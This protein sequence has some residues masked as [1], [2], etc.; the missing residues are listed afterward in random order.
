MGIF[1]WFPR[2]FI[3]L[4]LFAEGGDGSGTGDAGADAAGQQA[5]SEPEAPL[6]NPKG[7]RRNP[8]ADVRYGRQ[9]E[10]E[11]PAAQEET[12]EQDD[13]APG[14]DERAE[15]EALK[16]GKFAKFY[17]EDVSTTVR[18]RLKNSKQSDETLAKLQ[19]IL[20]E[21]SRKS[22]VDVGDVDGLVSHFLD[23]DSLYEE[24]AMQLNMPVKTLK[25]MK[26][27][28][29]SNAAYKAQQEAEE[30]ER[31]FSEHMARLSQQGEQ[32]KALYPG[33][34][35]QQELQDPRF[36]RLTSPE[37][38]MDV[39]TAYFALHHRELQ[40]ATVQGTVQQTLRRAAN[41]VAANQARPSEGVTRRAAP[42]ID[43]R[44]DPSKWSKKDRE[45]VRN[46]V[47]MGQKIV[48]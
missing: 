8:L 38:G 43:V 16:R 39:E 19:P 40:Q 45:E 26:Q 28:E 25:A 1:S 4:Q 9:P 22:G 44:S 34:D 11:Q 2:W 7:R 33:F 23:D 37:G 10:A 20:Q 27:L 31:V 15:W 24:E 21:L 14:Q 18:D 41:A 12:A 13:A 32:L 47:R 17:G 35:L 36:V 6:V 30:Q 46:R 29:R 48:L 5:E 3:D 42:S